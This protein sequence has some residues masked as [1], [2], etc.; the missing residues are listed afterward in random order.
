VPARTVFHCFTG[1]PVE[2]RRALEIGALLSFSGIVSFPSASD[3]RDAAALVPRDAMLVETDAPFLAP[4]PYRGRRNET[5][6]LPAVGAA[7]AAA[8]GEKIEEIAA[9]TSTNATRVFALASHT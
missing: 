7:L 2:A 5:A 8:R 3:V 6:L 4:V 9:A 1:G